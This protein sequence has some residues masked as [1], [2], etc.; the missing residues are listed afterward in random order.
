MHPRI[1][2]GAA[3]IAAGIGGLWYDWWLR[4][5]AKRTTGSIVDA[6]GQNDPIPRN[7][8]TRYGAVLQW[9]AGLALGVGVYQIV[10]YFVHVR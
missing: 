2:Y 5:R 7:G 3:F 4:K 8:E 6:E 10:T 1:L 9:I